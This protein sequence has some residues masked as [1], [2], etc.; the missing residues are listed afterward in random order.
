MDNPATTTPAA[1]ETPTTPAPAT[2][3]AG[4]LTPAASPAAGSTPAAPR[5]STFFGNHI[6]N[7]DGKFQEGWTE[8]LRQAGF[9]RLATK[10]AMAP[11]EPTFFRTLDETLAFVGKKAAPS[12]PGADASDAEI[13]AYRNS[14]G[15]PDSPES[16]NLKPE[17]L[18][19][20]IQWDESLAG[21]F[22]KL[23]HEHHVPQKTA[24]ALIARHLETQTALGSHIAQAQAQRLQSL[25][26]ESSST[27]KKE[28]GDQYET[29]LEANRAFITTRLPEADLSDPAL[30][31]A[32]SHPQ[33]VRIVDEARRAL[34][35]AP[36]PGVSAA[37]QS[38]TLS[39]RQQAQEI[40]KANPRFD[41]DP[42]LVKRVN[43]LYALEA[44]QDKQKSRR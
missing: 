33:I 12:Y 15:V 2:P 27:F 42:A 22:S 26:E 32:L 13:S 35:E 25:S 6:A 43:D 9:E 23:F 40:I 28:W 19:E 17:S 31:V 41:R 11:D 29:R 7:P 8:H 5:P 10:A 24:Q 37:L 38:G 30:A 39:P 1:P 21:E 14:A 36:L 44:A 3:A 18:P 16:Y 4:L 34:R 20:G